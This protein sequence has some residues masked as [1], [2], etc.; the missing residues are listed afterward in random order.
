MFEDNFKENFK[1]WILHKDLDEVYDIESIGYQRDE[2]FV[3]LLIP[4]HFEKDK[5]SNYN[6]KLVWDSI[7]SYVVTDE[8]Y[9]PEMWVSEDDV[10]QGNE[11]IWTFYISQSSDYLSKFKKE[12][13]LVLDSAKHFFIAGS[14][15]MADIIAYEEPEVTFE[16]MKM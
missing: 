15:L 11:E 9:R 14:N 13:Y 4:D 7:I 5:K 8:S 16:I 1:K 6:L 2:G 3:V 10:D 12:N